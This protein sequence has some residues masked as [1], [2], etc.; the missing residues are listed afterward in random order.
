MANACRAY[1]IRA[2]DGPYVDYADADGFWASAERAKELGLE[3]KWAIHP[4]Q[5]TL[6]NEIFSPAA[7]QVEWAR[8][9]V[10][11]MN[12]ALAQGRGAASLDGKMIDMAHLKVAEIV[13]RKRDAIAASRAA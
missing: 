11:T 2:I 4:S 7:E 6:A 3:G 12:E 9:L 10:S 13:Q 8:R 5:V 1:G